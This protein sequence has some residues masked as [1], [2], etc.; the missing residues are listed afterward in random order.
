MTVYHAEYVLETNHKIGEKLSQRGF[1]QLYANLATYNAKEVWKV[2]GSTC[3]AHQH[4]LLVFILPHFGFV[5][6]GRF[7]PLFDFATI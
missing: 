6:L 4:S 7:W 5:L 1:M 3:N 2:R